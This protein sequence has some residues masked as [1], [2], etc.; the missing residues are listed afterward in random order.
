M[1]NSSVQIRV[2]MCVSSLFLVYLVVLEV[3]DWEMVI[4]TKIGRI[5]TQIEEAEKCEGKE[6]EPWGYGASHV[7]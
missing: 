3:Y 2:S 4:G 1:V 5:G 7:E 6:L